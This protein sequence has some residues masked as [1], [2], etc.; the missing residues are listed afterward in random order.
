M[1]KNIYV[2]KNGIDI[3]NKRLT[4]VTKALGYV[5]NDMKKDKIHEE[6]DLAYVKDYMF[7]RYEIRIVEIINPNTKTYYS[8]KWEYNLYKTVLGCI[9]NINNDN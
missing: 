7:N 2:Y 5:A 1:R 4:N 6:Y 3:V 9:K 8:M